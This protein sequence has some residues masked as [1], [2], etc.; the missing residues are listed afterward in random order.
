MPPRNRRTRPIALHGGP[1]NEII[2]VAA[3]SAVKTQST[4]RSTGGCA[5]A[6]RQ[7]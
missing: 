7:R 4:I 2:D 3:S 6:L 5:S 1:T